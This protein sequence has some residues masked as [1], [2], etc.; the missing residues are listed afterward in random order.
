MRW[1]FSATCQDVQFYKK[2]IYV[3][4]SWFTND[5]KQMNVIMLLSLK[6]DNIFCHGLKM[7]TWNLP[8]GFNFMHVFP[9]LSLW[10][11]NYD[12]FANGCNISCVT[13][14]QFFPVEA[15]LEMKCIYY[16]RAND[17][18]VWS[19]I[20]FSSFLGMLYCSSTSNFSS[21]LSEH[22]KFGIVFNT[23]GR[24]HTILQR[25]IEGISHMVLR[26]FGV[27]MDSV[28]PRRVP[29]QQD[30]RLLNYICIPTPFLWHLLRLEIIRLQNLI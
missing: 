8:L 23:N 12:I 4:V 15:S 5:D 26:P 29:W 7:M 2:I 14:L 10:R 16:P 28:F 18:S 1:V 27:T 30:D 19:P 3:L 24:Q 22:D 17:I 13:S 6:F 11:R 25:Y 21:F 9:Y 20:Q